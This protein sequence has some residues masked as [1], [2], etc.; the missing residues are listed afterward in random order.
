MQ[1]IHYNTAIA[2][3]MGEKIILNYTCCSLAAGKVQKMIT[4]AVDPGRLVYVSSVP[5][6]IRGSLVAYLPQTDFAAETEPDSY[7]MRVEY[8]KFG[9]GVC[10]LHRSGHDDPQA[11]AVGEDPDVSGAR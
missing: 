5:S 11:R 4:D 7:L 9:V 2:E 3:R 8:G 6:D 10:R 1:L